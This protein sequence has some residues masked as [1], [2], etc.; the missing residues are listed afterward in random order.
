MVTF[1]H[2]ARTVS[3]KRLSVLAAILLRMLYAASIPITMVFPLPVAIL[4]A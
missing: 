2:T 3:E 1:G 4:Q